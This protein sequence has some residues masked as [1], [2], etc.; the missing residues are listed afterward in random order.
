MTLTW[1]SHT[2]L[3]QIFWRCIH[4]PKITFSGQTS[5]HKQ[6]RQIDSTTCCSRR[7][8]NSASVCFVLMKTPKMRLCCTHLDEVTR[9][10][11]LVN[12]YSLW[13]R[14]H[15]NKQST[16]EQTV[17][18]VCHDLTGETAVCCHGVTLQVPTRMKSPQHADVK[19]SP[20]WNSPS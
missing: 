10:H 20:R 4:T 8:K 3:T 11:W 13:C 16:T 14:Y 2:T 15:R 5:E 9:V 19:I 7:R 1:P 17:K 18:I 6:D 12:K